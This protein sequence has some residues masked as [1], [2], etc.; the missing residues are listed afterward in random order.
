MTIQ[1][2]RAKGE[3]LAH[4][5]LD[6]ETFDGILRYSI[7]KARMT[8]HSM[9]YVPLLLVDEIKDHFFRERINKV[10]RDYREMLDELSRIDSGRHGKHAKPF[11][12]EERKAGLVNYLGIMVMSMIF[13]GS[14][15]AI[16]LYT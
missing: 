1:E 2:A 6:E 3:A 16:W 12:T 13:T 15:M 7:R 14:L 4:E 5:K 11:F 9:D 10:S 8:G